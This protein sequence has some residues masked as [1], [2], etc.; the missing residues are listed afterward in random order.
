VTNDP[1]LGGE[2]DDQKMSKS[3]RGG[4]GFVSDCFDWPERVRG[5]FRVP[6]IITS[7]VRIPRK[8]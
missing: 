5:T 8:G 4:I 1:R 7:L 6:T 2:H 3:Y